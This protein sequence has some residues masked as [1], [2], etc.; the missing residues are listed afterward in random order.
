MEPNEETLWDRP[1]RGHDVRVVDVDVDEGELDLELDRLKHSLGLT[2]QTRTVGRFRIVAQ[3]GKGGMGVVHSAFDPELDRM[4]ALKLVRPRQTSSRVRLQ[5]RLQREAR[6]LGRLTHPNVVRVYDV[7]SDGDELFVAMELV[8]GPTLLEWQWQRERSL[9]ELLG[10]YLQA[11]A[12]LAAAHDAGLVHRDFKPEN[13]F[14]TCED[15]RVRVLV[16]DFGLANLEDAVATTVDDESQPSSGLTEAGVVLGT[17]GY[18]APEQ[19]RGDGVDARADQ[20]AFCVALWEAIAGDRPFMG[21]STDAMLAAIEQGEPRSGQAIPRRL[22]AVLRRG[23]ACERERRFDNLRELAGAIESLRGR[24]PRWVVGLGVATIAAAVAAVLMV[25]EGVEPCAEQERIDRVW[26]QG[27]AGLAEQLERGSASVLEQ[28]AEAA[29]E[30]LRGHAEAVCREPSEARQRVLRRAVDEFANALA[31]PEALQTEG[32][33]ALIEELESLDLDRPAIDPAVAAAIDRS[34][35]H[36]WRGEW[37]LAWQAAEQAVALALEAAPS[38]WSPSVSEALLQRGYMQKIRLEHDLALDDFAVAEAHAEGSG[39]A[40]QVLRARLEAAIVLISNQLDR[41]RGPR[42]LIEL[43]PLLHQH[44]EPLSPER[45]RVHRLRSTLAALQGETGRF[46]AHACAAAVIHVVVHPDPVETSRMYMGTAIGLTRLGLEGAEAFYARSADV[47]EHELP[48]GND[49]RLNLDYDQALLDIESQDSKRQERAREV[50]ERLRRQGS[51]SHRVLAA[52]AL[53]NLALRL[54]D[55][56]AIRALLDEL[57]ANPRRA[58]DAQVLMGEA[59]LGSIDLE[60]LDRVRTQFIE[61]GLYLDVSNLEYELA[62]SL[63]LS[64]CDLA[65]LGVTRLDD[66]P[67]PDREQSHSDFERLLASLDCH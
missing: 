61:R 17:P 42:V 52:L 58:D 50:L 29:V 19:L 7:G 54:D 5:A 13:V 46:F 12:G 18:M 23:L 24:R 45:A 57:D 10:V 32:W 14:V 25:R 53:L 4:V 44:T 55:V 67:S 9:D 15:D 26:A 41:R 40:A 11:A 28:R 27:R 34:R 49:Q 65:A 16:G 56:E 33:A 20:F 35:M 30:H 37:E 2:A 22:R 21:G 31:K 36:E 51:P 62:E 8:D 48:A 6:A 66:V 64:A 38:G 63:R 43:E 59:R 39:Y 60:R 47:L 3:L 1:V